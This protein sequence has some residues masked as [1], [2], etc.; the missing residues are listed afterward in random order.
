LKARWKAL[1]S[2]NPRRKAGN[3]LT[4]TFAEC[5]FALLSNVLH[6][7]R[8][9]EVAGLLV[10]VHRALRPGGTVAIWEM[11]GPGSKPAASHAVLAALFFRLTSTGETNTGN[12]YARWLAEAGFSGIRSMRP[13]RAPGRVLVVARA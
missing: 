11:E 13:R 7:L 3:L 4:D 1:A 5:E 8:P 6:H 12:Q 9:E 10:R 2:E